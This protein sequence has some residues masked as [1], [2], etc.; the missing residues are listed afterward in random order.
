MTRRHA[1]NLLAI[2]AVPIILIV[3]LSAGQRTNEQADVLKGFSD[4]VK[5]YLDLQKRAE[6]GL[7]S[8]KET[9]HPEKIE[10]RK[11]A[12]ASAIRAARADAKPG[13]IFGGASEQ[14]RGVIRDDGRERSAR[15]AFAAMQEVPKLTPPRVNAAYP[16]KAALATVPPLILKRLPPLP[17]GLEYRFMGRDLILR[18]AKSNL[19]VDLIHEAVPTTRK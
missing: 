14:F 11:A 3:G 8:L 9:D 19:I 1:S 2:S 5:Q 4:R 10:G 7:P 15:D 16:E 13:D 12:L 6:A 17:E 18:D